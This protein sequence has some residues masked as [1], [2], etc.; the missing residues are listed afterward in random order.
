MRKTTK[1]QQQ[2]ASPATAH[3]KE[4]SE[5]DT[6]RCTEKSCIKDDDKMRIECQNCK[7]TIHYACTGL[8]HINPF[9]ILKLFL[10][11]GYQK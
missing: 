11:K 2:T 1:F 3:N 7:R 4:E 8:P 10:N 5:N 6:N 9:S